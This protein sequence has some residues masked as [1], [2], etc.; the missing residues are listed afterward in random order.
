MA[1]LLF[2]IL[3]SISGVASAEELRYRYVAEQ[4]YDYSCGVSAVAT[5]ANKYR[6]IEVNEQ[7][8]LSRFPTFAEQN[9]HTLV[10]LLEST[11]VPAKKSSL[12][13]EMPLNPPPVVTSPSVPHIPRASRAGGALSLLSLVSPPSRSLSFSEPSS[14][15]EGSSAFCTL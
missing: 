1:F 7:D 11:E 5:L 12:P 10:S 15:L 8:L 9:L 13:P 4:E 14:G 2:E 6:G 3:L